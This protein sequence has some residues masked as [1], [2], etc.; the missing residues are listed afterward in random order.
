MLSGKISKV[1]SK[2]GVGITENKKQNKASVQNPQESSLGK[3]CKEKNIKDVYS[4]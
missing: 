4:E 2:I 3:F 1:I